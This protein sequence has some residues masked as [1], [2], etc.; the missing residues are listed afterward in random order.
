MTEL[1]MSVRIIGE[2]LRRAKEID[3]I[4]LGFSHICIFLAKLVTDILEFQTVSF[5]FKIGSKNYMELRFDSLW[6]E[7]D[8]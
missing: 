8:N 4:L 3:K 7:S 5:V 2:L 1:Q 6:W